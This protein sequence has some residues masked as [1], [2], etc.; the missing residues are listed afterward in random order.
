MVD[1]S[2]TGA[3]ESAFEA[4]FWKVALHVLLDC[5]LSPSFETAFLIL[6]FSDL[7]F[8]II[9]LKEL[10]DKAVLGLVEVKH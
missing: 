5:A 7:N 8:K 4:T 9:H 2:F 3:K 6:T 1:V 10:A